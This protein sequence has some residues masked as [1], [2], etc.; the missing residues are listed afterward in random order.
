MAQVALQI[1]KL[2]PDCLTAFPGPGPALLDEGQIIL[3]GFPAIRA[4][5]L[6]QARHGMKEGMQLINNHLAG[7]PRL[8][9]QTRISGI[10]DRL[11]RHGRIKD[12]LA[13]RRRTILITGFKRGF[14]F[15]QTTWRIRG[16]I[17]TI[18]SRGG[19]AF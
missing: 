14:S 9:Q 6:F 12:K 10:T 8:I 19:F 2:P 13:R 7:F 3:P 16:I 15:C 4:W 1:L 5:L 18:H 17:S 11:F